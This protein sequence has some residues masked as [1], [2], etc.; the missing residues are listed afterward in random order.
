MCA[1]PPPSSPAVDARVT[2]L[3][4]YLAADPTN[5]S[6]LAEMADA[7]LHAGQAEQARAT[8]QQALALAPHDGP[9]TYR[10]AVAEHQLGNLDQ[11]RTLLQD[12]LQAGA[13]DPAV[14]LAL[15]R[16]AHAQGDAAGVS[17]ALGTLDVAAWPPPVAAEACFL[18]MRALHHLG[19]VDQAIAMGEAL[20]A[21]GMVLPGPVNAALGTLYLD[22]N[23]MG[24]AA[25]LVAQAG[26]AADNDAELLAVGGFVAMND[27][28]TAEAQRRFE[29]SVAAVPTMGRAHL[30]LGLVHASAGRLAQARQALEQA[31][32]HMPQHLGSWHALAWMHLLDKDIEG[33]GRIFQHALDIDRNF[34]DTYGGLAIVAVLQ[35]RHEL[36]DEFIRI[37]QRLDRLSLNVGVARTLLRQ[38]GSFEDPGFLE[39]A[40]KMLNTQ[41]LSRNDAQRTLF[42]RLLSRSQG[43]GSMRRH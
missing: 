18:G 32:K 25:R 13:N 26:E 19:Q 28:D 31:T 6:L 27:A 23:R 39:E 20:A 21:T 36:A 42:E 33:A 40:L 24:D 37:G 17:Q 16:V 14:R 11:A 35:G 29:R 1:M 8:A 2:R 5:L 34:G 3:R 4:G 38:G 22:A 12:L 9:W 30:G 10:L 43:P 7:L 41:A 15:A